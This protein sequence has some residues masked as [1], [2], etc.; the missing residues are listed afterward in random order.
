MVWSRCIYRT[1]TP[2]MASLQFKAA[3]TTSLE[4][5]GYGAALVAPRWVL[6]AAHCL[7]NTQ[8]ADVEVILGRTQLSN[9]LQGHTVGVQQIALHPEFLRS[10]TL[11]VAL[12]KLD[13]DITDIQAITLVTRE[14]GLEDRIK[15]PTALGWGNTARN[16]APDAQPDHLQRAH[17]PRMTDALCTSLAPNVNLQNTFCVGADG[18]IPDSGDSGGPVFT[19]HPKRGFVQLGVVSQSVLIARLSHLRIPRHPA[20]QSTNIRPPFPRSSGQAVGAQ[21]R[22]FALLV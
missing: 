15:R 4:R 7:V 19:K 8:P 14:E 20:T 9:T 3:G 18:L 21:R 2:F 22:R 1:L 10:L 6:T 17:L 16:P 11:D 12:L 13:R 5:H